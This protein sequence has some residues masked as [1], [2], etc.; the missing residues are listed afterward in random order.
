MKAGIHSPVTIMT[1][2]SKLNLYMPPINFKYFQQ[3]NKKFNFGVP[4]MVFIISTALGNHLEYMK[5]YKPEVTNSQHTKVDIFKGK[6]KNKNLNSKTG[7][8]FSN[9]LF[10]TVNTH[11]KHRLIHGNDI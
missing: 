4:D 1:Y 5:G 10:L 11:K 7:V 2:L 9:K 3:Q 8:L 6:V